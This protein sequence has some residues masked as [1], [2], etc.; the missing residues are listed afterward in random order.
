[1]GCTKCEHLLNA[2]TTALIHGKLSS[3][4]VLSRASGVGVSPR[5]PEY[6]FEQM[7]LMPTNTRTAPTPYLSREKSFTSEANKGTL[8]IRNVS[9]GFIVE[10]VFWNLAG[11]MALLV[12]RCPLFA[13]HDQDVDDE[14][15]RAEAEHGED[16]GGVG[17]EEVGDLGHVFL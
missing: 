1:M 15:G 3:I 14:E 10:M 6:H 2:H 7:S 4:N 9:F 11:Y 13:A 5:G 16:G 12:T 17:Q 8:R